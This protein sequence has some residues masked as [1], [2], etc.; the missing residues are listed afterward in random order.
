MKNFS[1]VYSLCESFLMFVCFQYTC[2][3]SDAADSCSLPG[4]VQGEC[5]RLGECA[6]YVA[7]LKESTT[8]ELGLRLAQ[9]RRCGLQ[10]NSLKVCC[11][12]VTEVPSP[13]FG[14]SM[15]DLD[16]EDELP[17]PGVCGR[18]TSIYV[19]VKPDI[20]FRPQNPTQSQNEPGYPDLPRGKRDTDYNDGNLP[21]YISDELPFFEDGAASYSAKPPMNQTHLYDKGRGRGRAEFQASNAFPV[22]TKIRYLAQW[23]AL[24]AYKRSPSVWECG[25]SIITKRHVL[26]AAHC[27]RESLYVVR[28]GE[29]DLAE[30]EKEF[31]PIDFY[32]KK[33]IPHE[34]YTKYHNDIAILVLDGT[35]PIDDYTSM[36]VSPVCLL[37]PSFPYYREALPNTYI[38]GWG[39]TEKN[40]RP[41]NL[42][43]ALLDI[44]DQDTCKQVYSHKA[45]TIDERVF[46]AGDPQNGRD[47]CNGDSGGPLIGKFFLPEYE[48]QYYFHQ[49]GLISYGYSCSARRYI[50]VYTN[51]THYLPWIREKVTGKT[52]LRQ[53]STRRWPPL[54]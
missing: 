18:Y 10:G 48:E 30:T 22:T 42:L 14:T 17:E 46:C 44:V 32:I 54:S 27:I 19:D 6:Q 43:F 16:Y 47:A 53:W 13:K 9:E 33:K 5:V 49:L 45:L 41:T 50:G 7:L 8:T 39:E 31:Y 21:D 2:G 29:L 11:P 20:S 3:I 52:G 28:V 34:Q 15:D 36:F 25:G 51:V 26:T 4:D 23:M 35:I 12:I 37:D 40:E 1:K 38:T 24:L